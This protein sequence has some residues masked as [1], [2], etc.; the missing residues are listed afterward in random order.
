MI[1][2]QA[3][4]RRCLCANICRTVMRAGALSLLT[5]LSLIV[6]RAEAVYELTP[7]EERSRYYSIEKY[8]DY[9][10]WSH[11][12]P[13]IHWS[14]PE[15]RLRTQL[16]PRLMPARM[17]VG[18]MTVVEKK[19]PPGCVS[20]ECTFP[21]WNVSSENR[22][23]LLPSAAGRGWS[24]EPFARPNTKLHPSMLDPAMGV[25]EFCKGGDDDNLGTA[26]TDNPHG[27]LEIYDQATPQLSKNFLGIQYIAPLY[28][29][30]GK[31]K[32]IEPFVRRQLKLARLYPYRPH[33]DPDWTSV[34]WK[35]ALY[36]RNCS[37]AENIT[38]YLSVLLEGQIRAGDE[39]SAQETRSRAM[40]LDAKYPDKQPFGLIQNVYSDLGR[41][42][43]AK[44]TVD[45]AV[46][47]RIKKLG[48][49]NEV[50]K[51]AENY[52]D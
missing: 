26:C 14:Y 4:L 24:F 17:L 7:A 48:P 39:K 28:A 22:I 9:P 29:K 15:D 8:F 20:L 43:D 30:T 31:F 5:M 50:T 44:H 1:W 6:Q 36:D 18:D 13:S 52:Y 2:R 34:E 33:R 3:K 46:V 35:Q 32:V 10:P 21:L 37:R 41:K 45:E 51:G 38:L 23:V 25:A 16:D 11:I 49:S 42:Q 40:K 47:A 19:G 12:P 27:A